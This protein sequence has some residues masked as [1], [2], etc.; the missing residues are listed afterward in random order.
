[1]SRVLYLVA[2]TEAQGDR[3]AAARGWVK[4]ARARFVTPEP[5]KDDVRVVWRLDELIPL[6]GGTLMIKGSDYE[7]GSESEWEMK[8][9]AGN[10]GREGEKDRFD[11]FVAEGNGEW[12]EA[13]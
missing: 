5:A 2:A 1:M 6:P 9:W 13:V 11:R 8:R 7:D 4:I 12:I 3:D 10:D